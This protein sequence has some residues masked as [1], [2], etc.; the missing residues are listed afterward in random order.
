MKS[1]VN[2]NII[3]PIADLFEKQLS[4]DWD[5]AGYKFFFNS[6]ADIVWDVVVIYEN[7]KE[8]YE[9]CYKSGGLFFISGEPP[10]VKVYS[11]AFI[12]LFDHVISAHTL[13][14]PCNHRDQQALPWYFGY[15]FRTGSS[16]FDYKQIELM[17]VPEKKKKI[18]FITSSRKFLPGHKKRLAWMNKLREEFGDQIDFYGKGIKTV[19]DKAIALSS[20]EFSIC[21]ENSYE[22]DY[23]TEKIADSFLA[24][25]VPIYSGCKNINTY[26]PENSIVPLDIDD[27]AASLS[28]IGEILQNSD[29][30]YR[31]RLPFVK[32]SRNLLL[33]KYNL[34]PFIKSYIDKYIDLSSGKVV[35]TVID[36]YDSY[37]KDKMREALLRSKRVIHKIF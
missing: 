15:N 10:I 3:S 8:S 26:F 34:F 28:K 29:R 13:K 11:Q 7:I 16:S 14:H 24:Y 9:L 20:Y 35:K 25:T 21:I 2:I 37:P 23:W 22:Y 27:T 36:P 6:R 30:I 18:S 4:S 1:I 31:E 33:F 12:N 19:D 5:S 32:E 17:E